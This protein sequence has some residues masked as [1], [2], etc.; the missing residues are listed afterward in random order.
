MLTDVPRG[1]SIACIIF[2]MWP[3]KTSGMVSCAAHAVIARTRRITPLQEP[4]TAIF[5]PMVSY[6]I[7]FV[8]Q[9]VQK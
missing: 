8:E 7:T 4:F 3:R 6:P 5:L 2:W 9:V 1:S